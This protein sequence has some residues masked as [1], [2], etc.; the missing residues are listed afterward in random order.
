MR[1]RTY[2]WSAVAL[3]LLASSPKTQ[4]RVATLQ[5]VNKNNNETSSSSNRMES[6]TL[7]D[8][9]NQIHGTNQTDVWDR[10]D[11]EQQKRDNTVETHSEKQSQHHHH[12]HKHHPE[13]SL[14]KDI[15]IILQSVCLGVMI[16]G[17]SSYLGGNI[18]WEK[19][20]NDVR[21]VSLAVL[22]LR[23]WGLFTSLL[24]AVEVPTTGPITLSKRIAWIV[25]TFGKPNLVRYVWDQVL[26]T[27][28]R[29]F[30]QMLVAEAW[31][32]FFGHFFT[33][34]GNVINVGLDKVGLPRLHVNLPGFW[35]S[36]IMRGTRRL[37][38]R[39]FQRRLHEAMVHIYEYS[40]NR[41]GNQIVTTTGKALKITL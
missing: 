21:G 30:R 40:W 11:Q 20:W 18:P 4:A 28:A 37:F 15:G 27:L 25:F 24:M 5:L 36:A 13:L 22:V 8:R 35:S 38:Q 12:H 9:W 14:F 29:V 31:N 33:S 23:T 16:L 7:A 3:V 19:L 2:K 6:I 39:V 41:L 32:R 10:I 34:V 17:T 26:P 1:Y